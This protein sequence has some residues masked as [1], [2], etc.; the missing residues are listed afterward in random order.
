MLALK[1]QWSNTDSISV[2]DKQGMFPNCALTALGGILNRGDVSLIINTIEIT[3]L[4][5]CFE[6]DAILFRF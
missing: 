1:G 4:K 2:T 5:S 6:L 3:Y